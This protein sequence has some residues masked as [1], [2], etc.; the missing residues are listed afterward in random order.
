ML[1]TFKTIFPK[2]TALVI[3]SMPILSQAQPGVADYAY[4]R[5]IVYHSDASRC[6][7]LPP[8]ASF[9]VMLN[10]NDSIIITD[11]CPRWAPEGEPN[12]NGDGLY[13][14][15]LGNFTNPEIA[16]S[17]SFMLFFSCNITEEQGKD[18]NEINQLPFNG[19][20]IKLQLVPDLYLAPVEGLSAELVESYV[21]LTWTSSPGLTYLI[22]RRDIF[23][24]LSDGKARYQYEKIAEVNDNSTY[25]DT[26]VE[27]DH[28][29][30][31]LIIVKD[32][33]GLISA[34]CEEVRAIPPITILS[35]KPRNTTVELKFIPA[36]EIGIPIAGYNLYRRVEG[37]QYPSEPIA[38]ID[39]DTCY[40]DSRLT[41]N[42]IYY[43]QLRSRDFEGNELNTSE[44]VAATT[45]DQA[46]KYSKFASLEI[47][48]VLYTNTS[49]GD[50][51]PNEIPKI[52]KML[53]QARS[54]YWRNSGLK[55]NLDFS[56][57]II[58]E[59]L[60][61]NPDDYGTDG[62]QQDLRARGVQDLQYDA[63]F[64][65]SSGTNGFWSWGTPPWSFMGPGNS[66]GFSHVCWKWTSGSMGAPY[67]IN[68]PNY[69]LTWF[70]THEFQHAMDDIYNDNG[71][72]GMYHGD[73]PEDFP[74]ACGEEYDFQ[75]KMYHDFQD[76]LALSGF[77]G[78]ILESEDI[79]HDDIPDNDS[80]VPLDELRFGSDSLLVD[81]DND[82][83]TDYHE[84][85]AGIYEGTNPTETDTDGDG[86][87]DIEDKYPLYPVKYEIPIFS[88]VLNGD[89]EDDWHLL[90]DRLNFKT[91]SLDC[92]IY[93]N[94]DADYLYLAFEMSTYA[95]PSIFMDATADGWWH[96]RDNY[97]LSFYP[98]SGS[99]RDAK[100]LDCTEEAQNYSESI[101]RGNK[102]MWDND[103]KYIEHFGRIIENSDFQIFTKTTTGGYSIEIL[104]PQN[105]RS[106]LTL[107]EGDSIGLRFL[108]EK[109]QSSWDNWAT[110]FEQFTL[111][112]IILVGSTGIDDQTANSQIPARFSLEQNFPNPFNPLTTI[113]YTLP[114]ASDVTI[115]VFNIL[116]Q[117]VRTLT[118]S[119]MNS[120]IHEI[121]WDGRD[122]RGI[123]AAGG[124]YIY[125]IT[126]G[127]Y[128][129]SKKMLLIK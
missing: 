5:G 63:V 105:T 55:M 110:A 44:E 122:D 21:S 126:A 70:F 9:I 26:S 100:I 101:G 107:V 127:D 115:T 77:R 7:H 23:D 17:D 73:Q 40:T 35:A 46:Q 36:E 14:V 95:I 83:L 54:F 51:Q 50:I 32:A 98:E 81:T 62:V 31:Y 92:K 39:L 97:R 80:R 2:F 48:M 22:Y 34:R 99:I 84:F 82:D 109:M 33:A 94:W 42:T 3:L 59:Y 45:D 113:R 112:N 121:K 111:V 119:V 15:E 125:K 30:G 88:P 18:K 96:D 61:V 128:T 47:L 13:G 106:G 89:I 19:F 85:I 25:Q 103:S 75:A 68:E 16:V 38:H 27:A 118:N 58:E 64:R 120:G 20:N 57:L 8:E 76:W 24:V 37:S 79:D 124:I 56:Y 78:Q 71:N 90:V 53:E 93:A 11:Q 41:S 72:S 65:I 66:T 6:E 28:Y 91:T 10:N 29:Y 4:D 69:G 102:P 123:D 116:G 12:I 67:P 104:I 114:K 108:F 49:G 74:V 43:Y 129:N 1:N 86:I 87:S 60:D 52:K 117:K